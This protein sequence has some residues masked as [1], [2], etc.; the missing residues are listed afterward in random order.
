MACLRWHRDV[1]D[2]CLAV[3]IFKGTAERLLIESAMTI[4]QYDHEPLDFLVE[5]A[6]VDYPFHYASGDRPILDAYT[7]SYAADPTGLLPQWTAKVWSPGE[8]IQSYALLKRLNL[9]IH[10]H[11]AYRQRTEPGVQAA[12]ETLA[13]AHGSCR[14]MAFLFMEAARS[15]NFASRFVSG[16]SFTSLPP[17]EAGSTHAWAEVF[18]PG[19]GWKGFDP[20]QGVIVGDAHVPVSVGRMPDSVPPI[21][22]TFS[23]G[24]QLMMDANVWISEL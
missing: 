24:S 11:V 1:E 2:N 13:C 7:S 12:A 5:D 14:D 17:Q 16:Y 4:L 9:A 3:A 22:G 8:A 19:A 23:G 21:A 10:Q 15:L 6:A 20:T 18:L